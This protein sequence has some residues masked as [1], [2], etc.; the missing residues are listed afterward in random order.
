MCVHDALRDGEAEAGALRGCR[1]LIVRLRELLENERHVL[2][3]NP[4]ARVAHTH[5]DRILRRGDG[6]LHGAATLR[7]LERIRKQVAEDLAHAI[8]V[9]NDVVGQTRTADDMKP[10]VTLDGEDPERRLELRE[11]RDESHRPQLE[12][13]ASRFEPAHVEQLTNE[14]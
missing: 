1:G 5:L 10:N 2:R 6:E 9:P 14:S 11:K 13:P 7:K 8:L 12:L 3:R 4:G